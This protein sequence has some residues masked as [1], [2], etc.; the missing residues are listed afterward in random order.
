MNRIFI[1]LQALIL[2]SCSQSLDIQLQPEVSVFL[3]NDRD[4]KIRLTQKD[5]E[6]IALNDWLRDHRS[7][8]HATSG[9]YP[10]GVYIKSG[11]HGIQVTG[12]HVVIYSTTYSEP[13]A[14]Y[15]QKIDSDKLIEIKNL[16]EQSGQR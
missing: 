7:G 16:A 1:I 10:D 8:W 14:L 11:D 9:H 5:K 12:K 2:V 6:Y 3:S 4:K 15:I 13:R